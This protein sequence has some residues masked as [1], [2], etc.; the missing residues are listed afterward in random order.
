MLARIQAV[1]V[2]LAVLLAGAWCAWCVQRGLG[3]GWLLA[4]LVLTLAPHAP[5]LALEFAL[6][7]WRGHDPGVPRPR[8]AQLLRAWWGEV[9]VGWRVFGWRQPFAAGREP[10]RP[11][12]AGRTGVLLLHGYVCNRGL[13]APWQRRL[14]AQGVP[15]IALTLEPVFGGIDS[16]APA[17]D[18]AVRDLA[19]RTGRPPLLV[20]HSMGGLAA[21]AWLA[22]ALAN[23]SGA[24]D[25]RIAG[26]VTI[27]TPHQG[28]W[29]AR[30]G[31]TTNA[32]QMRLASRWLVALAAREPAGRH[33]RFTCFYGH[34]DNL[35][36]PAG[37][38]TLA[39]ADNRHLAGV[40][41]VQMVFAPAVID[42]V[43]AL[44]GAADAGPQPRPG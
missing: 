20:G 26:A 11:D 32:R 41:H 29:T 14:R 37:M 6:L 19:R 10:D 33:A 23:A 9:V 31:F 7:G 42:A 22:S 36:M 25:Q 44:A 1:L 3:P 34:A 28:T 15:C 8:P 18:A 35:V 21:R 13:W 4:G 43:L 27:G 5:V 12:G 30:L 16:Y 2:G 40:A 24:A 38:A 17:I 39:G